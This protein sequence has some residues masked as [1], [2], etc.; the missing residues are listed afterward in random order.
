MAERRRLHAR[1]G[2]AVGCSAA[3]PK[4]PNLAV[5]AIL[6]SCIADLMALG[7]SRAGA[8]KLMAVQSIIRME[9]P[10]EVREIRRFTKGLIC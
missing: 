5:P 8:V 3:S 6:E 7:M 4:D 1:L 2:E 10:E 9:S